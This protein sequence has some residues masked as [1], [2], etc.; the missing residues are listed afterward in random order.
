MFVIFSFFVLVYQIFIRS[1][2]VCSD[3]LKLV[4]TFE[5]LFAIIKNEQLFEKEN[6]R[7][8]TNM[9]YEF[10]LQ[11][12]MFVVK[13][14]KRNFRKLFLFRYFTDRALIF[15]LILFLAIL[16]LFF[17]TRA[18]ASEKDG[19]PVK[20]V[21]SVCIQPGDSIWSIAEDFYTPE[22]G[23]FLDY[24]AE[25]KRSNGLRGDS[26]HVGAYIIVPYFT[27]EKIK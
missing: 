14:R 5:H 9:M 20:T 13:K 7:R 27:T 17:V 12:G 23:K 4:L 26:I 24:V 25:I 19:V 18:M 3:F 8:A 11:P 16:S 10:E 1:S 6:I 2:D 15:F 22:C 21:T